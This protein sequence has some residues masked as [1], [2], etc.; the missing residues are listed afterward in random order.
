M[1]IFYDTEFRD[2]GKWIEFLSIGMVCEDGRE[3]YAIN[4]DM[5]QRKV[6]EDPWLSKNVWNQFPL[7]DP[8]PGIRGGT[9]RRLDIH[10]PDV[11][12][13]KQIARL[14]LD[15]VKATPEPNLVAYYSAHDHVVLCQLWG[16]MVDMPSGVPWDTDCLRQEA[17]RLGSPQLPHQE[18]GEHHAL[19]DAR[20]TQAIHQHLVRVAQGI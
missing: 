11:R 15:F 14:V 12:P 2:T 10:H 3:L 19:H 16:R 1:N 6:R 8:E 7:V 13:K 20:H 4:A 18:S 17:K 9:H 5:D